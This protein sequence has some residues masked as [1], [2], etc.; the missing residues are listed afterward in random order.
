[1]SLSSAR[2]HTL[3]THPNDPADLLPS[4]LRSVD[5]D[6]V[7]FGQYMRPTKSHMKVSRY[8]DPAEFDKWR[9][10]AEGMGFLYVA[11]GPLVRSSYKVGLH[12]A[13]FGRPHRPR[14][15]ADVMA[16]V[17][18]INR[19]ESSSSRTCSRNDAQRRLK[20]WR[21]GWWQ[22]MRTRSAPPS[23]QLL[24]VLLF[25]PV[26]GLCRLAEAQVPRVDRVYAVGL[27]VTIICAPFVVQSSRFA[28]VG[29]D[30][31]GENNRTDRPIVAIG[32][33]E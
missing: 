25:F 19:Q 7:T 16:H 17:W 1:V 10:V 8:V 9:S 6:V 28:S 20:R 32:R 11:S 4:G 31:T 33:A 3:C 21:E 29:S 2:L 24:E 27:G 23:S 12:V 5:V 13:C 26:R 22:P 18:G 30:G 15:G 14:R